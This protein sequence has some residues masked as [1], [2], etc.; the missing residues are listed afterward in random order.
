MEPNHFSDATPHAVTHYRPAEGPLDTESEAALRQIVRSQENGEVR[1][2]AAFPVA[3]NSV[4]IRFAHQLAGLSRRTARILLPL[5][6]R[7]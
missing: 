4:E 5:F 3:V 1:T 7:E 2:R 6:T